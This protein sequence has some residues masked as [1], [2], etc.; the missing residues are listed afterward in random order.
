MSKLRERR[1]KDSP[2]A[3]GSS[4][5]RFHY[6]WIV[7]A[8]GLLTTIGAHGL[9]RFAYSMIN[10]SMI[11]GL[12]LSYTQVGNLAAGNFIGYLVLA[13]IGGFLAARFGPRIVISLSLAGMGI[14]MILTGLARTY[15]FALAMR[16]LTGLG[17]GGAFVPAMALGSIW[18]SAKK[19]GLATGIVTAGIGIGFALS[20]LIVPP[21]LSAYGAAGWRSCWYYLGVIVI[22]L[23]GVTYGFI[24]NRPDELGLRQIGAGDIEAEG[25]KQKA[26]GFEWSKVYRIASVWH[27]GIV[28][29]LFGFSYIIYI[30][31]F[32]TYLVKEIGWTSGEAGRLFTFLGILSIFCGL[33]WGGI[34][35][36]IGR[37]GGAALAYIALAIAYGIFAVFPSSTAFYVSAV[38]FGLTA[39]AIPTIM[40]AAAGDYVGP[41]LAPAGLG[42]ITLFFGIGQA[43]GPS[44]GGFLADQRGSFAL[45]FLLAMAV[46]LLGTA[47]A[48]T[49]RRPKN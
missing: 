33:I 24:R 6:G 39:W 25:E 28:Y 44:I 36:I 9:G 30:N 34:S 38:F 18:F 2:A 42:L 1:T 41:R 23:A 47:G 19:R 22:I 14:T 16:T 5:R 43:I 4:N 40:A 20:G 37:K 10:P 49:L 3:E 13:T 46:S 17:N 15:E 31:F 12:G 7:I 35:D 11:D 48:L 26:K 8:M 32:A 29:F 27:L 21:I 45:S